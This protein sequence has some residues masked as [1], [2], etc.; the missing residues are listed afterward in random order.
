MP[1]VSADWFL[2]ER[3]WIIGARYCLG[4]RK[5][6]LVDANKRLTF[7]LA[8]VAQLSVT[9]GSTQ[10]ITLGVV[11]PT[12]FTILAP[13][14]PR[15]THT[16][17]AVLEYFFSALYGVYG[18][19][20]MTPFCAALLY[21]LIFQAFL[22]TVRT[23]TMTLPSSHRLWKAGNRPLYGNFGLLRWRYCCMWLYC[24]ETYSI[25]RVAW[26][27]VSMWRTAGKTWA[28]YFNLSVFDYEI[29]RKTW[30][31]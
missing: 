31:R 8:R 1:K 25:S 11:L 21:F 10:D 9:A 30:M 12:D 6:I 16:A 23:A 27:S 15:G 28:V 20:P 26:M 5:L 13:A 14:K 7:D 22:L 17:L 18:T 3:L 29:R 24:L 2:A 4:A 19:L